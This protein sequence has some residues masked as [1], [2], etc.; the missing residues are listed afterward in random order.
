[1][2]WIKEKKWR[3]KTRASQGQ[4]TGQQGH[5]KERMTPNEVSG[6]QSTHNGVHFN[7]DTQHSFTSTSGQVSSLQ[8][9]HAMPCHAK[10]TW[11]SIRKGYKLKLAPK[12]KKN[13]RV[14]GYMK[15]QNTQTLRKHSHLIPIRAQ[16]VT[17][18]S[19]SSS[20]YRL[21]YVNRGVKRRRMFTFWRGAKSVYVVYIPACDFHPLKEMSAE[22]QNLRE[23]SMRRTDVHNLDK[24]KTCDWTA[25]SEIPEW[26]TKQISP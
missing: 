24:E 26:K 10:P 3:K 8:C 17:L 15:R 11:K 19:A 22:K 18:I 4:L 2:H 1:M 25:T 20:S 16:T 23:K 5:K 6:E 21:Q 13:R 9:T 14:K 7:F 12:K